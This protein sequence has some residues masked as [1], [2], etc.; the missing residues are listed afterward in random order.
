MVSQNNIAISDERKRLKREWLI[1]KTLS[2]IRSFIGFL[3][4]LRG[5]TE[6]FFHIAAPLT[7]LTRKRSNINKWNYNFVAA[8]EQLKEKLIQA[9]SC[10]H[11]IGHLLLFVIRMQVNPEL[12]VLSL[13]LTP[14]ATHTLYLIFPNGYPKK[15]KPMQPM[16]DNSWALYTFWN[17]LVVIKTATNLK[18]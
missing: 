12:E 8:F 13:M 16:I 6:I 5:F 9:L 17:V 15:K 10:E 3:Q 2:E 1:F 18:S 7:E 4:Y 14:S 11:C